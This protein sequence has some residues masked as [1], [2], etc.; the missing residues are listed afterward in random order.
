MAA[1]FTK[2]S[3]SIV[4]STLWLEPHTTRI[5]WITM[6]AIADAEGYVGASLP[7]LANAARVSVKECED[8]LN[9]FLG[10]DAH[11][12]TKD[13]DGRRIVTVEGG[14]TLLNHALYRAGRDAEG[15]RLQ[16]REAKR[17]QR[18][19]ERRSAADVLTSADKADGQPRS[20]HTDRDPE[21]D[22]HPSGVGA[23]PPGRPTKPSRRLAGPRPE[24]WQPTRAHLEYATKHALDVAHEAETFGSYHD[25]K[26]STYVNWDAAFS[27]WLSNQVRWSKERAGKGRAGAPVV[28]RGGEARAGD[29]SWLQV[30]K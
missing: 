12:R 23:G 25:A 21:T 5:V 26:G 29:L 19:R 17:R 24:G 28:Q 30:V 10:P 11:S 6:L 18:Q 8:A 22:Q 16:N 7:G 3:G 15:R 20:A 1:G 13:Y 9:S 4:H 2:L 27:M 14:W